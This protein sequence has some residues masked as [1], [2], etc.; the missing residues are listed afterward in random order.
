V[1]AESTSEPQLSLTRRI[2]APRD[3]VYE[4]WTNPDVLR[5]WWGP[6]DFT[7]PEAVVDL[8]PGGSFRLVMQ[9][10]VGEVMV[11]TGTYR[12]VSPPSRLVYTWRWAEGPQRSEHE[13]LVTV[14]FQ[15]RGQQTDVVVVHA[16]FPPGH[17]LS[18][19]QLGWES[20]LDKLAALLSGRAINA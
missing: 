8:K 7:C 1:T 2:S 19:Y 12:E 4:A 11:L 18:Q 16:R 13:S 10:P 5:R 15:E 3:R 20:G 9:P 6:G 17:D 14:E